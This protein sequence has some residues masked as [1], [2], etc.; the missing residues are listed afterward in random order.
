[1]TRT[2]AGPQGSLGSITTSGVVSNFPLPSVRAP[3]TITLGPDGNLWFTSAE[4]DVIGSIT[5][6]G[7]V[8]TYSGDGIGD[9]DWITTGADGNLWFANTFNGSVGSITTTGTVVTY[10]LPFHSQQFLSMSIT[11]GPDGNLSGL[12]ILRDLRS[13][14]LQRRGL[15]QI[16]A[17][18]RETALTR[19]AE[20]RQAPTETSGSLMRLIRWEDLNRRRVDKLHRYWHKSSPRDHV[21]SRRSTLVH[22][23]REQLNNGR[24]TTDGTTSSY[25]PRNRFRSESLRARMV[26]CGSR[27]GW[28]IPSAESLRAESSPTTR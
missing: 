19:L 22:Q 18:N 11:S 3:D 6:S 4:S 1:M 27:I 2:G 13:L 9:P 14:Q 23:I 16:M 20:S 15:L 12:L 25:R 5:T 21:R 7:V 8:A 10:P 17:S 28:G 26:R 24:I